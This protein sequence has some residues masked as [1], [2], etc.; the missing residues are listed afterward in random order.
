MDPALAAH[1]TRECQGRIAEAR[2]VIEHRE[3]SNER[4]GPLTEA[5]VRAMPDEAANFMQLVD[6]SNR[7]ERATRY[8]PLNPSLAHE[9]EAAAG[10]EL[11]RARV[12]AVS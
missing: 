11:V 2:A 7:P 5:D 10:R 1:Q 3:G 12:A 6:S 4:A 9:T 8:R